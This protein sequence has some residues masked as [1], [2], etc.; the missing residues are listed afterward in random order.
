MHLLGFI[1][2]AIIQKPTF[3]QP[4]A[5]DSLFCWQLAVVYLPPMESSHHTMCNYLLGYKCFSLSIT[6]SLNMFIE[7]FAFHNAVQLTV[8][9]FLRL[10]L[11]FYEDNFH[12]SSSHQWI[13]IL[14]ALFWSYSNFHSIW[15]SLGFDLIAL[16]KSLFGLDNIGVK[17]EIAVDSEESN[18]F[19]VFYIEVFMFFIHIFIHYWFSLFFIDAAHTQKHPT[20]E[21]DRIVH[22]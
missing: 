5:E 13:Y 14:M 3:S 17:A 20:L 2:Y 18:C 9:C 22:F 6:S 1:H 16:S 10:S 15:A 21:H 19:I 12:Y 7:V 4:I 8:H 11:C